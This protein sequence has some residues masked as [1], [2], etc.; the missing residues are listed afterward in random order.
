MTQF[1][2]QKNGITSLGSVDREEDLKLFPGINLNPPPEDGIC[3][4]CGRHISELKPFGGPGD[5]LVGDFS[6][7]LLI[8]KFRPAAP[9]HEESEKKYEE[10]ESR[11]KEKGFET[12]EDYL[13]YKF[14]KKS[15]QDICFTVC[16]YSTAGKS[17]ECRD[18][19][20]LDEDEYFEEKYKQRITKIK[21]GIF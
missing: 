17:W 9:Y 12:V 11:Y 8:K 3:D 21:N 14:G 15:A 7:S 1:I 4:C 5:P 18:C 13:V 10:A 6:G 20:V 16:A 2:I 19:A